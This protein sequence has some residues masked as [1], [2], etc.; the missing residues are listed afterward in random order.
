MGLWEQRNDA[1]FKDMSPMT[2][3]CISRMKYFFNFTMY[4]AKTR[5]KE[6]MLA[7]IDNT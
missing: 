4:R 3:I 1:I 2:S 7:W 5:L 6:G